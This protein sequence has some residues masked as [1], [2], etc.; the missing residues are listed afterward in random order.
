MVNTNGF[1]V[2]LFGLRSINTS[3]YVKK[4]R[5]RWKRSGKESH[6]SEA[7]H[8]KLT[9]GQGGREGLLSC[10]QHQI[11]DTSMNWW[12]EERGMNIY[13]ETFKSTVSIMTLSGKMQYGCCNT[14]RYPQGR[15]TGP[16]DFSLDPHIP[17]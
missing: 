12:W 13:T 7:I 3:C 8:F 16:I 4:H 14:Q 5:V 6:C 10:L 2:K 9:S 15:K 11:L 17:Y 1:M